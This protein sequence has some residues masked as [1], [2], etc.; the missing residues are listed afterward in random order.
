MPLHLTVLVRLLP[1]QLVW[2]R[3]RLLRGLQAGAGQETGSRTYSGPSSLEPPQA[4]AVEG[5]GEPLGQGSLSQ[6]A[7]DL[8][9]EKPQRVPLTP[10]QTAAERGWGV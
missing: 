3:A 6:Q 2:P 1:S 10:Q 8:P 4:G 7:G 9:Q 5:G